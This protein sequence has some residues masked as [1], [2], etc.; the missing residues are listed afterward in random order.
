MEEKNW[1]K[2]LV[3]SSDFEYF[4][5]ENYENYEGGEYAVVAGQGKG[6][7]S[8]QWVVAGQGKG[9]A[10]EGV[11]A[12]QGKGSGNKVVYQ[13]V[14]ITTM[15]VEKRPLQASPNPF[16]LQR[17]AP[18]PFTQYQQYNAVSNLFFD[19]IVKTTVMRNRRWIP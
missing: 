4:D 11:V 14:P 5:G 2:E 3:E 16:A 9:I 8:G 6:A 7:P 10:T 19:L 12:G 1:L 18:N 17:K 15:P 13:A